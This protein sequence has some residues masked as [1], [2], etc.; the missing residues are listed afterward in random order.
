MKHKFYML[1]Y[2]NI[3]KFSCLINMSFIWRDI[4]KLNWKFS[5]KNTVFFLCI[6]VCESRLFI[7]IKLIHFYFKKEIL[8]FCFNLIWLNNNNKKKKTSLLWKFFYY[9]FKVFYF[10][11]AKNIQNHRETTLCEQILKNISGMLF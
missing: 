9:A 8:F 3:L 6:C 11:S 4:A 1:H 10:N 5:S 2:P 7:V